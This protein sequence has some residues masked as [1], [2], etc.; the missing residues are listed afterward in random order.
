MSADNMVTDYGKNIWNIMNKCGRPVTSTSIQKDFKYAP[1]PEDDKWKIDV[2]KQ[3]MEI[4][5][6]IVEIKN[7]EADNNEIDELLEVLCSS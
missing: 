6:N 4:R 5:W 2:A 1:V 3:L 7:I